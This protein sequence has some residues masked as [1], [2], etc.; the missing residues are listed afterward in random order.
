MF[1]NAIRDSGQPDEIVAEAPY[2]VHIFM[3]G[4]ES[5]AGWW[6]AHPGEATAEVL[7]LRVLNHAWMGFGDLLQG[8][9][10]A[11]PKE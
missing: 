3:G 7:A 10:W 4:V 5:L 2:Q 9:L 1:A 6:V 8:R 11:P